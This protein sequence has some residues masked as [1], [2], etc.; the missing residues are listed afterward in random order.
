VLLIVGG[1]DDMVINL[2]KE[3]QA[4]L[5]SV[6]F[7]IVDLDGLVLGQTIG[8]TVLIDVDAAGY[9]GLS[10]PLHM[11]TANSDHKAMPVNSSVAG[12]GMIK[13]R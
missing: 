8:D 9:A 12:Q 1:D 2:N 10:I 4:V 11:M 13:T 6:N 5:N 7:E 3:A